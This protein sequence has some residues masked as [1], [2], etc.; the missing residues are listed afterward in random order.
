MRNAPPPPAPVTAIVLTLDEEAN[1][2]RC[3]DSLRWCDQILV[4]DS[5]S[6]DATLEMARARGADVLERPWLGFARQRQWA[7]E[8][9]SVRHDWVYFVDADEWVSPELADEATRAVARPDAVAYSQRRRLIFLGTWI[10]HAGWYDA[11]MVRLFDRRRARWDVT[12]EF[13]E[14][15]IVDGPVG[16]LTNDLV[17]ED[18][19]G[20]TSWMAKHVRYADLEAERRRARTGLGWRRV[21]SRPNSLPLA[22]AIAKELVFPALPCKPLSLFLYM[23]VIRAGWRDGRAGLTF[24]LLHAWHELNVGQLLRAR[25]RSMDPDP[26]RSGRPALPE[27]PAE[28][29]G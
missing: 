16:Q 11:T 19:K 12:A 7:Q 17:D 20:L 5:G 3:L 1:I 28:V 2:A 26:R 21:Q 4:V 8:H 15:V 23:F 10:R 27:Q 18:R 14:R 22:R 6:V 25:A 24:C 29:G 9:E 13:A